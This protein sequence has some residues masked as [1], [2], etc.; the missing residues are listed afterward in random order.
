ME[1]EGRQGIARTSAID[2]ACQAGALALGLA[3]GIALSRALGPEGQGAWVLAAAT[4]PMLVQQAA[5]LG[6]GLACQA[7]AARAPRRLAQLHGI[8][9]GLGLL[10][11]AGGALLWLAAPRVLPGAAAWQLAAAWAIAP[12][13]LYAFA[14]AAILNGMGRAAGRARTELAIAAAQSAGVILLALAAWGAAGA[15]WFVAVYGIATWGGAA[16]FARALARHGVGLG[17][18]RARLLGAMWRYARWVYAA[19]FAS[20]GRTLVDQVLAHGFGGAEALGV[21]HRAAALAGRAGFLAKALKAAS[22]NRI[23]TAGTRESAEVSAAAFRQA[24]LVGIA[25]SAAGIAA[26][27]LIPVVYGEGFR[28][29]VLAFQI[30]LPAMALSGA[31]RQIASFASGRLARPQ[32]AAAI[33]WTTLAAQAAATLALVRP[34]GALAAVVWGAALGHALAAVLYAAW[35]A[36]VPGSPGWRALLVPRREDLRAWG[37]LA[38]AMRG[39]RGKA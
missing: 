16:A 14:A 29:S 11:V 19:E 2:S 13:M 35:F 28:P 34:A 33:D 30:L 3:A 36:R 22:W 21:Y 12:A 18:P 27:P 23:A 38:G 37:R 15:G 20:R 31:A 9:V 5:Q 24:M 1:G 25:L 32:V 10:G 39:G 8:A 26:A 17:R 6:M 7:W 4:G